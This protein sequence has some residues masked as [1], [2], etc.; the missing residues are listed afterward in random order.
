MNF[1]LLLSFLYSVYFTFLA[2]LYATR[3][4]IFCL[5]FFYHFTFC[6]LFFISKF[7]HLTL[8][9]FKTS[10]SKYS[11]YNLLTYIIIEAVKFSSI[12]LNTGFLP[13]S[14]VCICEECYRIETYETESISTVHLFTYKLSKLNLIAKVRS[15]RFP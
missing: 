2:I 14:H 8:R 10:D 3:D 1:I 5:L 15:F 13:L 12:H 7:F 4:N 11:F 6:S 9:R